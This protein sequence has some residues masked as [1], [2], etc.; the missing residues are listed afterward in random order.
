[1][2]L[3]VAIGVMSLLLLGVTRVYTAALGT[4][5]RLELGQQIRDQG[6]LVAENIEQSFRKALEYGGTI[7]AISDTYLSASKGPYG[8]I[9]EYSENRIKLT[10]V[11]GGVQSTASF[12]YN[13]LKCSQFKVRALCGDRYVDG[14]SVGDLKPRAIVI[15]FSMADELDNVQKTF[16]A[17]FRTRL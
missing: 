17:A 4:I 2:E 6:F 16:K 15:E 11:D 14:S 13:G 3:V 8:V 9:V 10:T 1:M 5:H 12:P 7:Q